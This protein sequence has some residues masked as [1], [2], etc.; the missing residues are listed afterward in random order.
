MGNFWE[1]LGYY[2]RARNLLK[3]SKIIFNNLN[4]I[5]PSSYKDLIELPGIGDYTASAISSF[6]INEINPV[7]DG[8]VYRF[9][10]RFI[11]IKIPI[12]T[13]KSLKE[14]LVCL[15]SIDLLISIIPLNPE[16]C[17]IKDI[18]I[19]GNNIKNKNKDK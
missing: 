7:V 2:S 5:F 15:I 10:S 12:N 11:G 13:N 14:I 8:N 9:L 6:S 1:G 19:I 18:K 16:I 4:G 3:T 17:F